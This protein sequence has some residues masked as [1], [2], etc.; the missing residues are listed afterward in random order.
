MNLGIPNSLIR[1]LAERRR[2]QVADKFLTIMN[3]GS[4]EATLVDV[5][6]PG[7]ATSLLEG[8]FSRAVVV[9]LDR[10][11]LLSAHASAPERSE[12]V[13]GD[14]S[15]LPLADGCADLVLSDNVLEHVPVGQRRAFV[16]EMLRV[17]RRGFMLTTPNYWFPFEP[18]YH[19]P[20]L[21]FVPAAVR[22]RL[23]KLFDF[24]FVRDG[25]DPIELLSAAELRDLLPG[26]HVEGLAFF[27]PWL[28]ETLIAWYVK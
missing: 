15:N 23:L 22:G 8:E 19:V 18:H 9:N 17:S 10:D 2:R 12:M 1:P 21:Q 16:R 25:G 26:I 24:G 13:L 3:P 28:P 20:L 7:M 6:G 4:G 11:A 27:C 14:G 5:G